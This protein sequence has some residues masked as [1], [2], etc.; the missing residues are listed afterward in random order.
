MVIRFIKKK[1]SYA[2]RNRSSAK[3]VTRSK[4]K[5]GSIKAIRLLIQIRSGVHARL[6]PIRLDMKKAIENCHK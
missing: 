6:V 2:R 3:R 4:D 1:R 5:K